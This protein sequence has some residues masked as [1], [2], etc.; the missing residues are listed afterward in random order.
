MWAAPPG[1]GPSCS[2]LIDRGAD[3][4]VRSNSGADAISL[5]LGAA[6]W[7]VP[8]LACGGRGRERGET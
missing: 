2:A 7:S 4:R 1:H 3:V 8:R 6:I 5:R